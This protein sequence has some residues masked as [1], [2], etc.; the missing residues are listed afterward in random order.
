MVKPKMLNE[1]KRNIYRTFARI[2]FILLISALMVILSFF[3]SF[4]FSKSA[5]IYAAL[6]VTQETSETVSFFTPVVSNVSSDTLSSDGDTAWQITHDGMITYFTVTPNNKGTHSD[7][8]GYGYRNYFLSLSGK[9]LL[10]T[11]TDSVNNKLYAG[12]VA[13]FDFDVWEDVTGNG[14][15]RDDYFYAAGTEIPIGSSRTFYTTCATATGTHQV[16]YGSIALNSPDT[17]IFYSGSNIRLK[18]TSKTGNLKNS[19]T[20]YSAYSAMQYTVKSR[21]TNGNIIYSEGTPEGAQTYPT[22]YVALKRGYTVSLSAETYGSFSTSGYVEFIP[23]FSWVDENGNNECTEV[24]LFYDTYIDGVKTRLV[25]IGKAV[26]NNNKKDVVA[27]DKRLGISS[28]IYNLRS[29]LKRITADTVV[30]TYTYGKTTT[31]ECF[32]KSVDPGGLPRSKQTTDAFAVSIEKG[33]QIWYAL[34][35]VPSDVMLLKSDSIY[36]S[37]SDEQR[38]A[39][40][41]Y[42]RKG[43]TTEG[44]LKITFDIVA[45]DDTG[46][47]ITYTAAENGITVFYD[48]DKRIGDDFVVKGI[49]R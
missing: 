12:N 14:I 39:D 49:Y 35:N 44:Y 5:Y 1:E 24:K 18:D 43:F 47:V 27:S 48:L 31:R 41:I 22:K 2:L 16:A 40:Y 36:Y 26:D 11:L 29:S 37:M 20:Q 32:Y 4:L 6:S 3:L 23:H 34:Y 46:A 17:S 19:Q 30:S 9:S 38:L 28:D 15:S 7:Y 8:R 13:I 21:I 45:H 10:K 33:Q 42:N 25:E